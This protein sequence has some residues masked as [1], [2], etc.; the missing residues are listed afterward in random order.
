MPTDQMRSRGGLDFNPE[1]DLRAQALAHAE[2]I[3]RKL[4]EQYPVLVFDI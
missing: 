2:V 4:A 3:A 1:G